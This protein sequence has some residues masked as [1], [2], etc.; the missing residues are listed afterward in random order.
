MQKR[1]FFKKWW[2]WL[3]IIISILAILTLIGIIFG[4]DCEHDLLSFWRWLFDNPSHHI[5]GFCGV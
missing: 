2:F 5:L 3:I 1:D 4:F